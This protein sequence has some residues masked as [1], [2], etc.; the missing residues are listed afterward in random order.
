MIEGK[1]LMILRRAEMHE[2]D[3]DEGMMRV[4]SNRTRFRVPLSRSLEPL[5]HTPSQHNPDFLHFSHFSH[6][7]IIPTTFCVLHLS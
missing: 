4:V 5:T 2:G 3:R 1:A 7:V 6:I